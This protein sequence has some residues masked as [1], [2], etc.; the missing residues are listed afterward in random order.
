[1]I[2]FI[3]CVGKVDCELFTNLVDV[4]GEKYG[5]DFIAYSCNK[6]LNAYLTK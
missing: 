2:R 1:M 4:A 5:V 6:Q 3:C